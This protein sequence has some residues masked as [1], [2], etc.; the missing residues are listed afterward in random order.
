M[1]EDGRA[2]TSTSANGRRRRTPLHLPVLVPALRHRHA[3]SSQS[4]T[5]AT[6]YVVRVANPSSAPAMAS[7]SPAAATAVALSTGCD[8][9]HRIPSTMSDRR[10]VRRRSCDCWNWTRTVDSATAEG[11]DQ[12]TELH[13]RRDSGWQHNDLVECREQRP[14]A[15]GRPA[16][17]DRARWRG[18]QCGTESHDATSRCGL[19]VHLE[20]AGAIAC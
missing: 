12:I 2:G 1:T 15:T 11:A 17:T 7:L 10:L 9:S 13:R 19:P 14:G 5:G 6:S 4:P 3:H 16:N 20:F 18:C 8:H